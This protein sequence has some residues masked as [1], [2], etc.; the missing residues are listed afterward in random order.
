M[1]DETVPRA[2]GTIRTAGDLG[3]RRAPAATGWHVPDPEEPA[4]S[5]NEISFEPWR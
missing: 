1:S 3:F 4:M 5:G 2:V